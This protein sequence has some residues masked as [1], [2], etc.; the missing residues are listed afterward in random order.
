M[1]RR[2]K[3]GD[4]FQEQT[5]GGLSL[6]SALEVGGVVFSP[7]TTFQKGVAYGGIDF[8]LFKYR[9]VAVDD[10]TTSDGPMKLFG[11]YQD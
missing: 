3:F 6:K 1:L 4:L 10:S 9:D 8:N 11:F 7:G 2:I 5:D